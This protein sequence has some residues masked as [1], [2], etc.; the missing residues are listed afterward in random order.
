MTDDDQPIR[1]LAYRIWEEEGRPEGHAERHWAMARRN[2][3][4]ATPEAE[5]M[6]P[7]TADTTT[8]GIGK[9]AMPGPQTGRPEGPK[10]EPP[11]LKPKFSK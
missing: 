6:P 10:A 9:A 4:A 11:P 2:L 5:A 1:E 8:G 3:E 7:G